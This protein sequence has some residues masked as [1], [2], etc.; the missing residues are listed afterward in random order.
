MISYVSTYLK[1]FAFNWNI[2]IDE[3]CE[4]LSPELIEEEF[5]FAFIQKVT[6]TIYK[7]PEYEHILKKDKPSQVLSEA[8]NQVAV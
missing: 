1:N 7:R 3:N 2:R 5:T 4:N 6:R 8:L